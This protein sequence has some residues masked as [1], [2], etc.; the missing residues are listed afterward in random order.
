MPC[1]WPGNSFRARSSPARRSRRLLCCARRGLIR[2][3]TYFNTG[4]T[5]RKLRDI[6]KRLRKLAYKTGIARPV[7]RAWPLHPHHFELAR[8]RELPSPICL[9]IRFLLPIRW[10]DKQV[11]TARQPRRTSCFNSEA[12]MENELPTEW[13]FLSRNVMLLSNLGIQIF[14][15]VRV[16]RSSS[17]LDQYA[18][19][20][21]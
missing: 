9:A 12:T 11:H 20:T 8:Y 16:L 5:V 1:K 21:N 19:R 3:H 4:K 10:R 14:A 15:Q 6:H 17:G 2:F 13:S 18:K 7:S